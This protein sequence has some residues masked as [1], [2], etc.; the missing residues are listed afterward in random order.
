[1]YHFGKKSYVNLTLVFFLDY[2]TLAGT[3]FFL[4]FLGWILET[5]A[6]YSTVLVARALFSRN[7][8]NKYC[9]IFIGI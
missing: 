3:L 6:A 9:S 5:L 8:L 7:F 2:S 4:N 1:M